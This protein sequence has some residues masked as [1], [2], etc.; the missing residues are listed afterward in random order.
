V[1]SNIDSS[2]VPDELR[3]ILRTYSIGHF[4]VIAEDLCAIADAAF[5]P[6]IFYDA[7]D[8]WQIMVLG[9]ATKQTEHCRA[10]LELIGRGFD[11]DA[12]LLSRTM[13]DGLAQITYAQL[14][15]RERGALWYWFGVIE[16]YFLLRASPLR[17]DDDLETAQDLMQTHGRNYLTSKG[18]EAIGRGKSVLDLERGC[19]RDK[20]YLTNIRNQLAATDREDFY[21]KFYKPSSDW[22]H[23]G[24]NCLHGALTLHGTRV[25]G[26][27]KDDPPSKASALLIACESLATNLMILGE[28]F[29]R[30]AVHAAANDQHRKLH[31]AMQDV[32]TAARNEIQTEHEN[33]PPIA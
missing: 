19:F 1:D 28:L 31:R 12:F 6:P 9:F 24:S 13:L 29:S 10:L 18:K 2:K 21:T 26:F 3:E 22:I 14:E 32:M 27:T 16:D 8:Y 30:A 4:R 5:Q 33:D 25:S 7:D 23:W 15:S 20:W 11:R 17:L